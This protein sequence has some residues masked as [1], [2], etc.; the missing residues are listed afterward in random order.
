M[1][2]NGKWSN[3]GPGENPLTLAGKT[4]PMY[5]SEDLERFYVEY[6]SE[7]VP[8]GLTMLAVLSQD[9][10]LEFERML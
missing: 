9:E 6:H 7:W 3:F 4:R 2:L 8:R 10:M 5:S 1:E